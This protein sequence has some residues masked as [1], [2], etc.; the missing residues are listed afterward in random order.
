M[1]Q[2]LLPVDHRADRRGQAVQEEGRRVGLVELDR[3]GRVVD[4]LDLLLDVLGREA[5]LVEDERRR[6][7]ELD[8]ALQREHRVRGGERIAGV[9]G[10]AVP[11]LEGVGLAVVGDL[12]ALGDVALQVRDVVGRVGHQPVV[13]V[14]GIFGGGELEHLGRIERDHVVDL[15]GHDQRV[16]RRLGV[17]RRHEEIDR[18]EHEPAEE[19]P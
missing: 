6:L 18:Q 10:D 2:H 14:G 11:D 12:P 4:H 17:Q 8:H 3:E 16:L 19:E 1:R 9:E 13:D 5:E 15:V 7:V